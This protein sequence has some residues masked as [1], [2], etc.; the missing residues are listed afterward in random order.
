MSQGVALHGA[1]VWH[2]AGY[3][4]A[5]VKVGVID[6]GFTGFS[7]LMGSELPASVTVRC[8]TDVGVFTS[9]LADCESAENNYGAYIAETLLDIAPDATLY[10]SNPQS[11]ADLKTA[12]DWMISQDVQV[13]N[14]SVNNTWDG[15]GDGTSPYA[16]SPLKSV[17][18][19]VSG[20]AVWANSV[21]NAAR[22][23]WHG[24]FTDTDRDGWAK[25]CWGY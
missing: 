1:D 22:R 24:Q 25:L 15:P 2:R 21:G 14:R 3:T 9:N 17:D 6:I 8:Y 18:A 20:G 10:I 4:G 5:G 12:V 7:A 23:T 16:N 13:I 11:W 19:A